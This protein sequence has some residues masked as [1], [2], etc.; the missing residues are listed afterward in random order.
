MHN[1]LFDLIINSLTSGISVYL[2]YK[3]FSL[4]LILRK[5]YNAYVFGSPEWLHWIQYVI[6]AV[7]GF[8]GS[9]G[10]SI[11]QIVGTVHSIA[12]HEQ[13]ESVV[14]GFIMLILLAI[15]ILINHIRAEE[16]SN[17]YYTFH[18]KNRRKNDKII[19]EI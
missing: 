7:I 19:R 11:M 13:H 18:P 16:M 12:N 15:L 8:V 1:N 17:N 14:N 4:I 5:N 2:T 6:A 3:I 10:L 9:C